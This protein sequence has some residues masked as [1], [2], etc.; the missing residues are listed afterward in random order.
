MRLPVFFKISYDKATEAIVWL[1]NKKPGI[2]I[3]HV[4]KVL[5]FADKIH[6]NQYARPVLGDTYKKMPFG[7]VP[8]AVYDLIKKNIWLSPKQLDKI[9]K[10][11]EI[12]SKEE[13]YKLKPLRDPD[14]AYFSKSDLKCL[15]ESL[16]QYGDLS[17]DE[18]YNLT[19]SEKCYCLPQ[20]NDK[21]DYTLLIDDDNP[22]RDEIIEKITEI[23][24]YVQV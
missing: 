17:F 2:D 13:H 24:M 4:A 3:Y 18:L 23:S 14:M 11:L 6:I 7:P 16:C 22:L 20:D 12:A 19:H 1:A 21:I 5:F 15:E 10:S 8:S 9:N